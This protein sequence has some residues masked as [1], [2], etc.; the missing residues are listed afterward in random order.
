MMRA[1]H[2]GAPD[3]LNQ[4]RSSTQTCSFGVFLRIPDP[5]QQPFIQFLQSTSN[6]AFLASTAAQ[7]SLDLGCV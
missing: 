3:S 7:F 2:H 5:T 4:L 6:L 1:E